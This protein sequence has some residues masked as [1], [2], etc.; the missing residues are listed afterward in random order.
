V[1]DVAILSMGS[2]SSRYKQEAAGILRQLSELIEEV[3]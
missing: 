2:S 3:C 1:G